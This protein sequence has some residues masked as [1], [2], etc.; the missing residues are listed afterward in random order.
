MLLFPV[1]EIAGLPARRIVNPRC[2]VE[3]AATTAG[4]HFNR[5]R[6]LGDRR[7]TGETGL[8]AASSAGVVFH[9][10]S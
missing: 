9:F 1:E 5:R 4:L 3:V 6:I 8:L 2:L 7:P 10:S